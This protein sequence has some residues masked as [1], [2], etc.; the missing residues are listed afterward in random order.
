MQTV[1]SEIVNVIVSFIRQD[2]TTTLSENS[3]QCSEIIAFLER[4]EVIRN[5]QH[6]FRKGKSCLTNLIGVPG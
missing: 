3:R 4:Y 1:G 6:G 2:I 5:T